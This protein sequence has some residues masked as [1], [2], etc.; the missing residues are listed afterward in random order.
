MSFSGRNSGYN[1]GNAFHHQF[2]HF[3]ALNDVTVAVRNRTSQIFLDF[4]LNVDFFTECFLVLGTVHTWTFKSRQS[5]RVLTGLPREQNIE[6]VLVWRTRRRTSWWTRWGRGPGKCWP[7]ACG[8]PRHYRR[9]SAAQSW[10]SVPCA[11][12]SQPLSVG[13]PRWNKKTY[14]TKDHH[15]I[16]EILPYSTSGQ[17][18]SNFSVVFWS[19][20]FF[21][22]DILKLTDL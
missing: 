19:K 12:S 1:C 2:G 14:E 9:S 17:N 18:L 10:G 22:K 11:A 3:W 6:N 13:F 16:W 21:Q 15:K 8:S 7:G 4:F 5:L 20:R